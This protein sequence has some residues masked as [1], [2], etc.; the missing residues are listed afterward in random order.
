MLSNVSLL[1]PFAGDVSED[2]VPEEQPEVEELDEILV[3]ERI[4]AHKDKKVR[5]KVARRSLVKFNNYSPMDAKW[6][7]EAELVVSMKAGHWNSLYDAFEEAV[8]ADATDAKVLNA[9]EAVDRMEILSEQPHPS[10]LSHEDPGTDSVGPSMNAL[11][12]VLLMLEN[13]CEP[14]ACTGNSTEEDFDVILKRLIECEKVLLEQL[15]PK[16][17]NSN[18]EDSSDFIEQYLDKVS[19]VL[20]KFQQKKSESYFNFYLP[21]NRVKNFLHQLAMATDNFEGLSENTILQLLAKQ[22]HLDD[23]QWYLNVVKRYLQCLPIMEGASSLF[24]SHALLSIKTERLVTGPREMT[25]E[26]RE[27]DGIKSTARVGLLGNLTSIDA[28]NCLLK[29]PMLCNILEWSQWDAVFSPTLGPLLDWLE[30]QNLDREFVCLVT[31]QGSI[32]RIDGSATVET[33][34]AAAVRGLGKETALQLISLVAV[35]GGADK[36]PR[37]L[38]KSHFSKAI[39]LLIDIESLGDKKRKNPSVVHETVHNT[40]RI[41]HL[42]SEGAPPLSGMNHGSVD[43]FNVDMHFD[44]FSRAVKFVLELFMHLPSEFVTFVAPVVVPALCGIV[45]SAPLAMLKFCSSYEHKM[46]LHEVGLASGMAEW[47]RDFQLSFAASNCPVKKEITNVC[48]SSKCKNHL[49]ELAPTHSKVGLSSDVSKKAEFADC[50]VAIT[51]TATNSGQEG[52]LKSPSNLGPDDEE[53]IEGKQER[54]ASEVISLIRKEEFG[55]DLELTT[56]EHNLL[57]KQHARMGR[58]LRCLSRELYSQDSHYVLELVQNADDNQYAADV[59]AMLVFVL[60]HDKVVVVNNELGFTPSNMKALCDV[61]NSTKTGSAAGYIGQKGIGFKSVFRITDSPEIHSKGF[62]VKFDVSEG[63]IGF[64]LPTKIPPFGDWHKIE[65]VLSL[66]ESLS[67]CGKQT[68]NTCMV[69]PLKHTFRNG[70]DIEILSTKLGDVHPSLLLFLRRLCCITIKDDMR[71][72]VKVMQRSDMEDGLVRVS[73]NERVSHW[74]VVKQQLDAVVD[75]PG[76]K[77][78]EIAL[79]FPLHEVSPGRYEACNE[80]QQVFAFLPLRSYGL[81]FIVQGDF[82]L[83]SSREDLDTDSPWNQW[84]LSEIPTVCVRAVEAFKQLSCFKEVAAKAASMFLSFLPHEGEVQGFFSSLPRMIFMNLRA[85]SCLPIEGENGEWALPCILLGRWNDSVRALLPDELLWELLGLRY[86]HREVHLSS[87]LAAEL[88]IHLYGSQLL[89]NFLESLCSKK[90]ALAK[91]GPRWVSSL[92][93]ALHRCGFIESQRRA[94][95]TEFEVADHDF[96]RLRA[97]PFIPLSNGTYTSVEDG[98]LWLP[99]VDATS[100][101]RSTG[102]LREFPLLYS[103]LRMVDAQLLL[104]HCTDN[105]DVESFKNDMLAGGSEERVQIYS[106]LKR[107]GIGEISEHNVV[108]LHVLPSMT[109]VNTKN[110]SDLLLMQCLAFA[111]VHLQSDCSHCITERPTLLDDLRKNAIILTSKGRKRVNEAPLH[112]GL[113]FGCPVDVSKILQGLPISWTEVEAAYL[114]AFQGWPKEVALVKWRSFFNELGVADFVKLELVEKNLDDKATSIWRDISWEGFDDGGTLVTIRDWECPEA[115]QILESLCSPSFD[116]PERPLQCAQILSLFDVMWE[117]S[118]CDCAATYWIPSSPG[119]PCKATTIPSFILWLRSFPWIQSSFDGKM[120]YPKELFHQCSAVEP[121]L[122]NNAPY[123]KPQVKSTKLAVALGLQTVVT[124]PLMLHVLKLWNQMPIRVSMEQMTKLYTCLWNEMK[125]DKDLQQFLRTE[126]SIFVPEDAPQKPNETVAGQLVHPKAVV[127]RDE[128]GCLSLMMSNDTPSKERPLYRTLNTLYP[129]LQPFF[130]NGCHIRDT[131]CF[132]EYYGILQIV[133]RTFNPRKVLDK[134][135]KVFAM[136]SDSIDSG[137]VS[138]TDLLDWKELLWK[139]DSKVFPTVQ[140]KWVSLHCEDGI[141]CWCDDEALGKMFL[142]SKGIHFMCVDMA[143]SD[144][145][146]K[147]SGET[148]NVKVLSPFLQAMNIFPLSKVSDYQ[149]TDG[150]R[151]KNDR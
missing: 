92:L 10:R 55:M 28:R 117:E 104:P 133:A 147:G 26:S 3:L 45:P 4:L 34:L 24:Y 134:V 42:L 80:Y 71:G 74:L 132:K 112:F 135:L 66:I 9:V 137:S 32:L 140:N 107:L 83:P 63:N 138:S 97:L 50:N 38:L 12:K 68:W 102:L 51:S 43:N 150:Y 96:K 88:G 39:E 48:L 23:S 41:K 5:G 87:I 36:V 47:V 35:Y 44:K 59:A 22:F 31:C 49:I 90:D 131:L 91:L 61:G 139:A 30:R 99:S 106:V 95:L 20:I 60:Q 100:A 122:G 29:A 98:P 15:I 119:A 89:V 115:V 17:L 8:S 11:N 79:A 14:E 145:C 13:M 130:V 33:L 127:W 143:A 151:Q 67:K 46:R 86:L 123:A 126:S 58:A 72:T 19:R 6:M 120:Y 69:L 93:V 105:S 82:V 141:L 54:E 144:T 52:N 37:A 85:C 149:P 101:T 65:E 109:S 1:R 7:E 81:K 56:K 148:V 103:E 77:T 136:W 128:T 62:H 125:E 53:W 40:K 2:M 110:K 18:S 146:F 76:V 118:Y 113:E 70:P 111:M 94:D 121:L 57:A 78:T 116:L 64:V 27:G 73:D 16:C 142:G 124:A 21:E 25:L 108:I 129:A 75:R 114:Q 84:L